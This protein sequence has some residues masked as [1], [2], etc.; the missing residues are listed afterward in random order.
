MAE[1][2]AAERTEP[3]TPERL[4]KAREE[5]QVLQSQEV[6]S[7][8]MIGGALVTATLCAGPFF[9][10]LCR[11]VRGGLEF[12][13]SGPMG[14]QAFESVLYSAMLAGL[15]ALLPFLAGAVA[16]SIFSSAIVS[17]LG[18]CPRAL[19]LRFDRVSPVKGLQNLVSLKSI[20]RMLVS[21]V[22]LAVLLVI[23]WAYLRDRWDGLLA[24]H[25][26]SPL[27]V[28]VESMRLVAGLVLRIVLG[29][30]G[31]ALADWLY[32]RW[33]YRRELRMTRQEV[34][35]ERKQYEQAPEIRSRIRGIQIAMARK[36]MLQ[37]VPMA[38]VIITNPTHYAVALR[39]DA[40]NMEAPEVLAKGAD[41]LA[42]KI[43]EIAAEH[44]IP[45]V[46]RPALARAL[47]ASVE[48]GQPVPESLFI[49]VAEVLAMIYR[50][51]EK[52][53]AAGLGGKA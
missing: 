19:R 48:P 27:A 18:W 30:S 45:V 53:R 2:P 1:K 33:Q 16:M 15:V 38:D 11:S 4:R 32:Q 44:D 35:E 23:V 9:E 29:L 26:A 20:V 31:I 21:I 13:Y 37:T 52:R 40:K 8:L 10:F 17:G 51:R 12:T 24:L 22:K 46:E 25:W 36:R 49:A 5:G 7:A 6:P 14:V 47:Y 50:L 42:Q 43:R 39:Y 34:K 41:F 3:P 28:L